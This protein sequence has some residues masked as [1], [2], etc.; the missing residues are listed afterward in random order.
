MS[1]ADPSVAPCT[2][3]SWDSEFFGRRI[4]R[5]T[6]SRL[7]PQLLA[8][9]DSWRT[10]HRIDCLYFLA[11]AGHPLTSRLA[12]N[13]GFRSVDIRLTLACS[14][15][16]SRVDRRENAS[17]SLRLST[18]TDL[19]ELEAIARR[20]HHDSRF[21]ADPNF[22]PALSDALYARWIEKASADRSGAV[23]IPEVSGVASGYISCHLTDDM[24][25]HIG[26]LAVAERAQGAG[27]GRDLISAA[28]E[29]FRER[30]ARQA[31]VVTQGRNVRAQRLYQRAGFVTASVE[32]WYHRWFS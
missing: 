31:T 7:T 14:L 15:P 12:E 5:V 16:E 18:S 32:L 26:L 3:L 25:G 21:Y 9:I 6:A 8:N 2:F 17:A 13:A 23:F 19:E 4:A 29:W 20:S 10:L 1:V 27:A 22:D 24:I 30:G 28:L 11:D